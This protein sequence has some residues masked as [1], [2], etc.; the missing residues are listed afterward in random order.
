M[1]GCRPDAQRSAAGMTS[2]PRLLLAISRWRPSVRR[3][4]GQVS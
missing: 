2:P 3:G 1:E 4:S